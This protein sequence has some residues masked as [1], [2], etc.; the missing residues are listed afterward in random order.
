[1]SLWFRIGS[2]CGLNNRLHRFYY[3]FDNWLNNRL[4]WFNDWFYWFN[5]WLCW[6]DD[7]FNWLNDG[8]NWFRWLLNG[9]S[10]FNWL[11]NWFNDRFDW[12]Y[13]W[14]DNW[15][16]WL[17]FDVSKLACLVKCDETKLCNTCLCL[18]SIESDEWVLISKVPHCLSII[19]ISISSLEIR[20]EM[21][22]DK[23]HCRISS[24]HGCF[25]LVKALWNL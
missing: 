6:F 10:R 15:L 14:F 9:L 18:S 4:S 12:L 13:N 22:V 24:V 11:Y 20:I 17:W 16:D 8:F 1:M 25:N 19:L 2:L 5:N 21:L 7:W 3:R 23:T